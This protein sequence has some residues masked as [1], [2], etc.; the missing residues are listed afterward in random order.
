MSGF[1]PQGSDTPEPREW[2]DGVV[3]VAQSS[4]AEELLAVIRAAGLAHCHIDPT[5]S[6][7]A[8]LFLPHFAYSWASKFVRR[9]NGIS[10]AEGLDAIAT[11]VFNL[12]SEG[13]YR[14]AIVGLDHGSDLAY[15]AA[16]ASGVS[17][18]I[19]LFSRPWFSVKWGSKRPETHASMIAYGAVRSSELAD[20]LRAQLAPTDRP[21]QSN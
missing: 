9:V 2:P 19:A 1:A 15:E 7:R 5:R 16:D 10:D 21:D 8:V 20:V 18:L 13:Y 17:T 6:R 4:A 3:L 12:E 14:L 11:A